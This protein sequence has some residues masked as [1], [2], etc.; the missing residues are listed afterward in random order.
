MKTKQKWLGATEQQIETLVNYAPNKYW[1]LHD[2]GTWNN[3]KYSKAWHRAHGGAWEASWVLE[4]YRT[5]KTP[6]GHQR[7]LVFRWNFIDGRIAR[8][9]EKT[10]KKMSKKAVAQFLKKLKQKTII[11][12]HIKF[13][14]REC[15]AIWGTE[16]YHLP[17]LDFLKSLADDKKSKKMCRCVVDAFRRRIDEKN[18][19]ELWE[20][21]EKL[22][23]E[24]PSRFFVS[25]DDSLG[26]GNCEIETEK[27]RRQIWSDLGIGGDAAVRADIIL[28]YRADTYAR[29]ACIYS[30]INNY[31]NQ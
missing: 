27:L 14:V 4:D 7:K 31:K 28:K 13:D 18:K 17:E 2:N 6:D 19:K 9:I 16:K 20:R 26:A 24:N 12:N 3:E 29:R 25:I 23:A 11:I 30:I 15:C 1:Y 8:A 21:A 5:R 22:L 10:L